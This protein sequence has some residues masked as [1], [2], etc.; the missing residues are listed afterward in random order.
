MVTKKVT[1]SQSLTIT[2][3]N[4]DCNH[5]RSILDSIKELMI[6][7]GRHP[8]TTHTP[9]HSRSHVKMT[10]G[11]LVLHHCLLTNHLNHI[12]VVESQYFVFIKTNAPLKQ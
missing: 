7:I 6:T 9:F 10:L 8:T 11:S 4:L 3:P 5:F 12:T 2:A 1:V